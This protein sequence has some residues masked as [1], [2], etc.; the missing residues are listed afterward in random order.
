MA[1]TKQ[2]LDAIEVILDK[3]LSLNLTPVYE[4]IHELSNDVKALREQIQQLTITLDK[5]V[6]MM[7]DYKEEFTILKGEVDKIKSFI[8]EKFGVEIAVQG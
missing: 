2:D 8:K 7:S 5:F 1:L 4:E 3:K 6:K